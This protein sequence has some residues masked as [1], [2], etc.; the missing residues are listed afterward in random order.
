MRDG[1]QRVAE[2]VHLHWLTV[3]PKGWGLQQQEALGLENQ[4][5]D[6][7]KRYARHYNDG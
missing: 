2:I 5:D 3:A 4:R 6:D 7:A 1:K